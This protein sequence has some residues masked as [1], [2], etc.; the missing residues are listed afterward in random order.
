MGVRSSANLPARSPP[1]YPKAHSSPL[2]WESMTSGGRSANERKEPC[3]SMLAYPSF[4]FRIQRTTMG[5]ATWSTYVICS[6]TGSETTV[7]F[8][9]G[10]FPVQDL[11][12]IEGTIFGLKVRVVD[13][14]HG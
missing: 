1:I 7:P 10:G 4:E 13:V 9:S 5:V 6:Y 14:G 11:V 12:E 3:Q 8:C 2:S